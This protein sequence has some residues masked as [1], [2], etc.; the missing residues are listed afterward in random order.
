MAPLLLKVCIQNVN[1]NYHGSNA[2]EVLVFV[3]PNDPAK[4]RFFQAIS[5]VPRLSPTFVLEHERFIT[6]L[7]NNTIDWSVIVFFTYDQDDL[8]L[9]LSLRQYVIDTRV[10]MVLSD[11]NGETVKMGF[12]ISPSLITNANGDFSDVIAV[13]EKISTIA[14]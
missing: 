5:K 14:Q 6:L 12:T 8:A 10:I 13:L 9:A 2:V 7:R 11:W 4:E 3:N 1:F